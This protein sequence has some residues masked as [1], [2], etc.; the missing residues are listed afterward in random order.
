M[1]VLKIS[2]DAPERSTVEYAAS[3][4]HRGQVVGVPTDTFYGLSAD[5]FNLAAIGRVYEI[6]GR[7]ESKALPI[8]VNSIE[9]A[10]SLVRDVPDNFLS[11]S[12]EILAWGADHCA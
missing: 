8:L 11:A 1:E 4:I 2:A 9:Q 5:P 7:P 3:F 12:F 6:K 10:V